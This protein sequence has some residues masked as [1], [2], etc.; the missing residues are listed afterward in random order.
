MINKD[1]D[2]QEK[3]EFVSIEDLVPADH[4]LRKIAKQIDFSFARERLY[5]LYCEDNGRPAVNPVT[6]FKMLFIGYMFGIRSERRL[7]KEIE[8]NLAYRWFLGYGLRD[9]IPDHS[10][11]SQNRRRRFEGTDIFRELFEDV[12]MMAMKKGYIDG[13]ELYTD[14]THLKANAN[15]NKYS[16]KIVK[17]NT[18]KYLSDLEAAVAEDREKHGKKELSSKKEADNYKEI[19]ESLTDKDSGFMMRDGKP[20]GF[21]YLDHR[22]CDGK[23]NFITDVFTTPGN[24]N[25]SVEYLDRLDY[26]IERFGFEVDVAGIDAGYNTPEICRGLVKR[27]IFGVAGYR[28]PGGL[29]GIMKKSRFK[30]DSVSD[31]YECPEGQ[32][33]KYMTTTR[34]GYKEY[35]SDSKICK[36][37]PRLNECTH[38]KNNKRTINR[39]VWESYKETIRENRLSDRGKIIMK[40]R[41]ETVERSFADAKELHG[42]RYARFRGLKRVEEQCLMTAIVQNIKKLAR[43]MGGGYK[44]SPFSPLNQ[45]NWAINKI[46]CPFFNL[47]LQSTHSLLI[48]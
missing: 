40:R 37:C 26:Q 6:L 39:H 28:N 21:F 44:I 46:L 12:V 35:V 31:T 23:H 43:L 11:I 10:T 9:K 42:Y 19:K 30:Y 29:K 36:K 38:S 47:S 3:M 17:E 7:I 34:E 4:I 2:K 15:K 18:Q 41:S 27:D 1:K 5:P 13:K 24:I 33:L 20:E 16:K 32:C 45:I 25:D 48:N 8:V 22:T 14:S